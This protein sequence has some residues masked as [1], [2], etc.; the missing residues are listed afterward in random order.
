MAKGKYIARL[1]DDDFWCDAKKLE[2]QIN[3]LEE[4]PD[5]IVAGGGETMLEVSRRI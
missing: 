3:F 1:D 2:K 5:Y 4:N